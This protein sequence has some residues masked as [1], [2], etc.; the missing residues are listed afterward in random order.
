MLLKLY[1]HIHLF[2]VRQDQV[3]NFLRI[4][5]SSHFENLSKKKVE[6]LICKIDHISL[7]KVIKGFFQKYVLLATL[8]LGK[9]V[10]KL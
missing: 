9:T 4:K 8:L 7:Q 6:A 10:Y 2:T 5:L 1:C 3:N